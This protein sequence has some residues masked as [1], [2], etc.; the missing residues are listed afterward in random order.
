LALFLGG[1]WGAL[2]A[3][4]GAFS[5]LSAREETVV[6]VTATRPDRRIPARC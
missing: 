6:F 3:G 2:G 4:I 1:A 5:G